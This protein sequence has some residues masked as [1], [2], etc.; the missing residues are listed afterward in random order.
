MNKPSRTL[1]PSAFDLFPVYTII[2]SFLFSSFINV[3]LQSS[4]YYHPHASPPL[5]ILT[6]VLLSSFTHTLRNIHLHLHFYNRAP[7]ASLVLSLHLFSPPRAPPLLHYKYP[8]LFPR[9]LPGQSP[10][11]SI[12]RRTGLLYASISFQRCSLSYSPSII[13]YP[14][15]HIQLT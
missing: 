5:H 4:L 15:R 1:H 8:L 14:C 9:I 12:I 7:I 2:L 13:I 10:S 3:S 11:E 6:L